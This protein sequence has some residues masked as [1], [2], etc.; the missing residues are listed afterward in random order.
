MSS[1]KVKNK[2]R[3]AAAADVVNNAAARAA[4]NAIGLS[5]IPAAHVKPGHSNAVKAAWHG[6]EQDDHQR[7][8][9]DARLCRR[10][11]VPQAAIVSRPYDRGHTEGK[12]G[13]PALPLLT[14]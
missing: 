4:W 3:K 7:F 8:L 14:L 12:T 1:L 10:S 6:S 9:Y 11:E 2:K 13:S 5:A